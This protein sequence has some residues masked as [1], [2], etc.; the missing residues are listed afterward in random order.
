MHRRLPRSLDETVALLERTPRV[1]RELLSDLPDSWLTSP[2]T[3]GGWTTRDVVG[4]L[5]SGELEDWIP[6]AEII[7]REGTTRPFDSFDRLAHSERD[8]GVPLAALVDRF[9]ELRRTNLA[10]L[11]DLVASEADL[12]R[13]GQHPELGE[14]TLGQLIATW[15]V[16]DLDHLGQIHAALAGSQDLA[17]GPWKAYL[18][19]LVRRDAAASSM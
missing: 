8:Q 1:V 3:P 10:R 18:G 12:D 6:R 11:R 19:I 14:V 9:A 2:D 13:R 7:L 5:I 4:H 16:H 17:V 15:A